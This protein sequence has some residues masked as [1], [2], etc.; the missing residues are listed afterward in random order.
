MIVNAEFGE[1]Q[2]I[3]PEWVFRGDALPHVVVEAIVIAIVETAE[4]FVDGP[5]HY[6]RGALD[7]QIGDDIFQPV[8]EQAGVGPIQMTRSN[9][10]S[11]V[12]DKEMLRETGPGAGGRFQP[13]RHGPVEFGPDAIVL[14]QNMH[15]TPA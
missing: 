15:Q 4:P 8:V 6:D 13:C 7:R 12:C 2:R 14:M 10:G 11:V 1:W 5:P 3:E 9:R